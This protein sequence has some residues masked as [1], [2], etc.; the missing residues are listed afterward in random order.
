MAYSDR[1]C[2]VYA[3]ATM[4]TTSSTTQI[5]TDN[6]TLPQ[7]VMPRYLNDD[8]SLKMLAPLVNPRTRPRSV[9]SMP[10]VSTNALSLNFATSTP[11]A[12]PITRP[13]SRQIGIDQI[14]EMC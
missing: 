13:V 7:T 12:A 5:H 2:R 14:D 1:P 6:G 8:G 10:S 9:I 4:P 11:L 3:S